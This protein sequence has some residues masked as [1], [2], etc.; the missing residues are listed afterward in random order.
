MEGGGLPEEGDWQ[1]MEDDDDLG[2]GDGDGDEEDGE[3]ERDAYE[4]YSALGDGDEENVLQPQEPEELAEM[5]GANEVPWPIDNKFFPRGTPTSVLAAPI[6]EAAGREG[7]DS[8][9]ASK[10]DE[11]DFEAV[12]MVARQ[13]KLG[14]KKGENK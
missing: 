9:F 8:G 10:F 1:A 7:I 2:N 13:I 6:E 4:G 12:R 11:I 3:D 5:V 14:T